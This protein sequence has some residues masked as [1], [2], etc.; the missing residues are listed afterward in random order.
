M[1]IALPNRF[2]NK[3]P[4]GSLQRLQRNPTMIHLLS[5]DPYNASSYP[6]L[7]LQAMKVVAHPTLMGRLCGIDENWTTVYEPLPIRRSDRLPTPFP[8]YPSPMGIPPRFSINSRRVV[9]TRDTGDQQ[10][11]FIDREFASTSTSNGSM[12]K[13]V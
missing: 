11:R 13:P 8:L 12:K 10:V 4:G 1:K 5:G 7:G 2:E 9:A 3:I 6:S